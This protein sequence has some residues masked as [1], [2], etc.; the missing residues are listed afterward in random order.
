[1]LTAKNDT[2]QTV[3]AHKSEKQDGM[4][5]CP[6]C[7]GKVILKK[8]NRKVDHFAHAS[9]SSCSMGGESIKHE[10]I[11]FNIY[12]VYKNL[13]HEVLI[14]H[15]IGDRRCDVA[16]K[17]NNSWIAIEIQLSPINLQELKSRTHNHT[18]NGYFT[19]WVTDLN[20][21]LDKV[22]NGQQYKVRAFQMDIHDDIHN[23]QLF[24]YDKDGLFYVVHL[25]G[26]RYKTFK[27]YKVLNNKFMLTDL[28]GSKKNN[29]FTV[30]VDNK[31]MW[32]TR[33]KPKQVEEED[34]D[35]LADY[36]EC[37]SR[38]KIGAGERD[39]K[40]FL[41]AM[42]GWKLGHSK[43]D[44]YRLLQNSPTYSGLVYDEFETEISEI[45]DRAFRYK[46]I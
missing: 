45:V 38:S 11:K 8:C 35:E 32:W 30:T 39:N 29:L 2:G 31:Q 25:M 19:M 46:Y 6:E 33:I 3:M 36:M 16:V 37:Y 15:K 43:S 26:Y 13:G 12:E 23:K 21:Q 20:C 18:A 24:Q 10:E 41:F 28:Y 34:Y 40:T 1:M 17:I 27:H 42:A 5:S 14:E 22:E 9:S 44:I 4:F 7:S